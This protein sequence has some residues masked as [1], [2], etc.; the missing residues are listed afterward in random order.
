MPRQSVTERL[1]N[2]EVLLMDGGTGSELQRRGVEVLLGSKGDKLGPWSATANVDAPDV[3]QQ[4]HQDYLRVGA[5]IIISNN[6]RTT[7]TRLAPVGLGDRWAEYARAGGQNAVRARN[8][9]NPEAYVAGGMSAPGLGMLY[10]RSGTDVEIMGEAEYRREFAEHSRILADTGVDVMLPEFV[11][12]IQ[13]CV[14]AVDGCAE[15]G[16]PVWLG[17]PWVT[18]EGT[19]RHGETM[20][21]LARALEG[22]PISA[23]LLMCSSP[24]AIHTTLP[25]L[26]QAFTGPIGAYPN[27]GYNP[28]APV[29]GRV[30]LGPD[31]MGTQAYGPTRLA[32]FAQEWIEMGAQIVGGCCATGPEH[33]MAMKVVVDRARQAR[34]TRV[35][36]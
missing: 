1:R 25:R 27:V 24:D 29:G 16:R 8:A 6:F 13:D 28:M 23:V 35:G 17:V 22:H 36:A 7:R 3:V 10:D 15:A 31:I 26:R 4:V 18:M 34:R 14:V 30:R 12:F 5:D 33:I 21:D 9:I 11:N 32:E 2:G 19:T 20:A